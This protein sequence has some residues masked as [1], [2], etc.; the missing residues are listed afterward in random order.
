[1]WWGGLRRLLGCVRYSA[2]CVLF[3]VFCFLFFFFQAEDGIRD[4][5]LSRGLGDVNKSQSPFLATVSNPEEQYNGGGVDQ[6][7]CIVI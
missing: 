6:P 3:F 7:K 1:M 5:F 4:F 2:G